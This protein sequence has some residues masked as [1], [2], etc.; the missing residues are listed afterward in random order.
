MQENRQN[1]V[2]SNLLLHFNGT[3]PNKILGQQ[4]TQKYVCQK[5]NENQ[6]AWYKI[7]S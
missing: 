4:S 3:V 7:G 2:Y 6:S 1:H 5:A